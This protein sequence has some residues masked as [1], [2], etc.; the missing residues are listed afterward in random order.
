MRV[1]LYSN[2]W[3]YY[4]KRGISTAPTHA[5]IF[6]YYVE[7]P[8]QSNRSNAHS[9]GVVSENQTPTYRKG[10]A[11]GVPLGAGGQGVF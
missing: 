1:S 10:S 2:I 5:A 6:L 11:I 8:N 3:Q 4:R 7:I 9:G